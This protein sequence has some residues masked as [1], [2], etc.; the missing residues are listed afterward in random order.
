MKPGSIGDP[1]VYLGAT[2]KQMRFANGVTAWDSSSPSKYA[3]ASV[4]AVTK[5]LINLGDKRW[6]MPPKKVIHSR[7][8]Q[9]RAGYYPDTQPRAVVVVCLPHWN[10]DRWLRSVEWTS[11]RRYQRWP[12]KWH[13]HGRATSMRSCTFFVSCKSTT[14]RM[15]Y[16]LSYPT[17]D[18]NVF[19]PND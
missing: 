9:A 13:H 8:L 18:M 19:K 16:D 1:D 2:I 6:S 12:P 10:A 4:D 14:T 15:A 3:R 7:G 17:I 11:S 5:Y